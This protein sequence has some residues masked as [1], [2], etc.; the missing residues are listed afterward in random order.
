MIS[1]CINIEP[2]D[3]GTFLITCPALPEV[4]TF[5][6]TETEIDARA[7]ATVAATCDL[8]PTWDAGVPLNRCWVYF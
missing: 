7:L 5:A 1:Y 3:N 8:T 6:E 2:N 4:T